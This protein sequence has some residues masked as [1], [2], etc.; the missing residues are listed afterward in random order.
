MIPGEGCSDRAFSAWWSELLNH[1]KGLHVWF[2]LDR[3]KMGCLVSP[4]WQRM[5]SFAAEK[6]ELL[7]MAKRFLSRYSYSGFQKKIP[8]MEQRKD[9]DHRRKPTP[10][11]SRYTVYCG[12]RSSF[13][14]REDRHRGG[15]VDRYSPRLFSMLILIVGLNVLDAV[16]TRMILNCGGIESERRPGR[17]LKAHLL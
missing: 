9:P 12:R 13:R 2:N 16:F 8:G 10:M 15:Y 1:D 14:R 7:L 5:C 17:D 3:F 6:S 11:L 4:G